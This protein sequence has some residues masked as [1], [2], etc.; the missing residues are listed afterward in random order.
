[1]EYA[2]VRVLPPRDVTVM[3][4][5]CEPRVESLTSRR[6]RSLQPAASAQR[7]L[8]PTKKK[9]SPVSSALLEPAGIEHTLQKQRVYANVPQDDVTAQAP[10]YERVF[11]KRFRSDVPPVYKPV[12]PT[13]MPQQRAD[14]VLPR[15]E[16]TSFER[17]FEQRVHAD[18]STTDVERHRYQVRA[19][20]IE[21]ISLKR[22]YFKSLTD[23]NWWHVCHVVQLFFMPMLRQYILNQTLAW[24]HDLEK[25]AFVV[26]VN[27]RLQQIAKFQEEMDI[28]LPDEKE[29]HDAFALLEG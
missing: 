1:M 14:D 21:T 20:F 13:P 5:H 8:P 23:V 2:A 26:L 10:Y 4:A 18:V 7:P 11:Q 28:S 27:F 25:Q 29:V 16:P 17:T 15:V 24:K 6:K 3:M 12:E 19:L 9:S 22:V